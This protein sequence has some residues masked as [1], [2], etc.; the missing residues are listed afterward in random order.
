MPFRFESQTLTR[1]RHSAPFLSG[2]F[3]PSPT[4]D[5]SPAQVKA[6][7]TGKREI[8]S[9]LGMLT[10]SRAKGVANDQK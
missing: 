8:A 2:S 7:K 5:A 1:P 10:R 3:N 9:E 6:K 4:G